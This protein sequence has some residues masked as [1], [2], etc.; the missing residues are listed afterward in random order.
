MFYRYSLYG[1]F[2]GKGYCFWSGFRGNCVLHFFILLRWY[3]TPVNINVDKVQYNQNAFLLLEFWNVDQKS[4]FKKFWKAKNYKIIK[5]PA[6]FIVMTYRF[7]FSA[8]TRCA[9]LLG[10]SFGKGKKIYK[11][12]INFIRNFK[13]K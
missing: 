9:T 3:S 11:I 1:G 5:V 13:R 2:K 4:S 8:L 12:I 10:N 7:V 6:E